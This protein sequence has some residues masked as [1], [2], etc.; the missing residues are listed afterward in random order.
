[1]TQEI[2]ETILTDLGARAR[3]TIAVP[4]R[5][6]F[7]PLFKESV[8]NAALQRSS[9]RGIK[10]FRFWTLAIPLAVG[11][12]ALILVIAPSSRPSAADVFLEHEESQEWESVIQE[13]AVIDSFVDASMSPLLNN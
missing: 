5:D 4:P 2:F 11:A 8:T 6:A 9:V 12:I 1:M 7:A 3:T 10:R 13:D